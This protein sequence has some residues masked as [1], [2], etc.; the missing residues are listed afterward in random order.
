[1]HAPSATSTTSTTAMTIYGRN[2]GR[3]RR[4]EGGRGG[5]WQQDP[6][7]LRLLP[8]LLYPPSPPFTLLFV[9]MISFTLT[10]MTLILYIYIPDAS[11]QLIHWLQQQHAQYYQ[12]I[13]ASCLLYTVVYTHTLTFILLLQIILSSLYS[14][15]CV[16]AI[17]R[18]GCPLSPLLYSIYVMGMVEKLE[19]GLGV[20]EGELLVWCTVV[21]Y[22][23]TLYY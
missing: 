17:I 5:G 18:Q 9:L 21:W 2:T 10:E 8:S 4:R 13:P 16:H 3:R 15:Y 6:F 23:V 20:K 12:V 7:W 22:C 1:M 19:E 11:A 14:Q